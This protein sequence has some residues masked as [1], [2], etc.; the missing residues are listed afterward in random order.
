M[1]GWGASWNAVWPKPNT[2]VWAGGGGFF[3][4]GMPVGGVI[5]DRPVGIGGTALWPWWGY[6]G[7]QLLPFDVSNSAAPSF[8]SEVNLATNSWWGFSQPFSSGTRVYLSHSQSMVQ[9]NSD[10]PNGIWIQLY[11]LDVVDYADPISPTIR[12]PVNIPGSLQG[13]SHEGELLYTTG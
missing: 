3:W 6:G 11:N 2:L 12:Q 10:N 8:A 7:G 13:L 4:W 9:T 5:T 1:P